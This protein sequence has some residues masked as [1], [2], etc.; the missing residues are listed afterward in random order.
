MLSQCEQIKAEYESLKTL[1]QEFDLER[2]KAVETGN[3]TRAKELKAELEKKRNAL[4]EKLF[5]SPDKARE[6]LGK[7][8][9]LGY[10]E[11]E[12]IFGIKLKPEQ[13]PKIPFKRE[14]LERAKG[15]NQMLILQVDTMKNKKGELVPVT[16]ENLKSEFPK[17]HDGKKMW[18]E[19]NWYDN[20][21]FFKNETPKVG[22]KLV[23]R[24]IIPDSTSK[25][26]LEQTEIIISHIKKEIFQD[27]PI[28]PIYQ[29]AIDE[30]ESQRSD[31]AKIIDSD[32]KSAADKLEKLQ[33]TQLARESPVEA[34]YRLIL[35]D[36]ENKEKLFPSQYTWTL[37]RD[38]GGE[39]VIVGYFGSDGADVSR[40]ASA[41]G[42]ILGVS[43]S[44]FV[45]LIIDA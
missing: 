17:A 38:S 15:L 40:D 45:D 11:A 29:E 6:I 24:E 2:Q 4:S 35:Q 5:I 8:K 34:M 9:V 18:Y 7:K 1:K 28:P 31:I 20:E 42:S 43:F 37:G 10:Q 32:W 21:D 41:I 26:Y 27:Q 44:Q 39:F 36:Q 25:N 19:Q 14:D 3:L 23:S 22:W 13:I 30:F 33:I 16:L 12:R